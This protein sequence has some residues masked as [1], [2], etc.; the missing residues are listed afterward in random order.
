VAARYTVMALSYELPLD[1][2]VEWTNA[3]RA[4]DEAGWMARGGVIAR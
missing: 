1:R 4:V 2:L 3:L